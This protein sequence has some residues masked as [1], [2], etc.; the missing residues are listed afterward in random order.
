MREFADID[1][2]RELA[3]DETTIC[4][5]RHF[6]EAKDLGVRL[7]ELVNDYLTENSLFVSKGHYC[8]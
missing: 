6:F 4:K 7:F 1:L 2:G 5:F 3:P 8:G